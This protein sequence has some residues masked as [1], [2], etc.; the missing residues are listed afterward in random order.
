MKSFKQHLKEVMTTP[1]DDT[2]MSG[3]HHEAAYWH[4]FLRHAKHFEQ[5]NDVHATL[6]AHA[7]NHHAAEYY[8]LTGKKI[9]NPGGLGGKHIEG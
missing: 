6:H 7:A 9:K 2:G 8:A 4:H 5:G 3:E 1:L